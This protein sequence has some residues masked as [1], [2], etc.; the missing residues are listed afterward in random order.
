[1]ILGMLASRPC[2]STGAEGVAGLL[3]DGAGTIAEPENDPGA[4]AAALRG[5]AAEP[6]RVR[7]EGALAARRAAERFDATVVAERA[8]RLIGGD[9]ARPAEG[10]TAA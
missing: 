2:V 8:E 9:S 6:E 5:Y 10:V 4:V 3:G 1:M 7:R